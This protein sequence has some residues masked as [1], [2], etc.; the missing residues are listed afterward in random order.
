MARKTKAPTHGDIVTHGVAVSAPGP[1]DPPQGDTSRR[2]EALEDFTHTTEDGREFDFV[3][4]RSYSVFPEI[5]G[6]VSAWERAGK[7]ETH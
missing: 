4:N 6:R 2:F 5:E 7:I 3:R 1:R